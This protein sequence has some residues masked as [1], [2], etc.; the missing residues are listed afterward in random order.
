MKAEWY[1][2]GGIRRAPS[3]LIQ[4]PL[5]IVFSIMCMASL[6]NSTGLPRRR[7][8][9]T[10]FAKSSLTADGKPAIIGVSKIPGAIVTILIP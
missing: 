1:Y 10:V 7:G 2:L 8:K 9:G 5:S 4:Q 6:A 3:N